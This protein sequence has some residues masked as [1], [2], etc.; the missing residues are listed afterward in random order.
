MDETAGSLNK[1]QKE[2]LDIA[3]KNLERLSRLI[4][5]I[6]ELQKINAGKIEFKFQENDLNEVAAEVQKSMMSLTEAKG[7]DFNINLVPD[8]PKADFDR[9]KI[10]QVFTNLVGNAIKFTG[11]GFITITT[12]YGENFIRAA[13]ADTGAGIPKE[14]FSR[15]FEHF[16]QLNDKDE[17][18]GLGLAISKEII[19]RHGGK[20]WV[21]SVEGRGSTFHFILPIKER[22][23]AR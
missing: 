1:D 6:L 16:E 5:E 3:K 8:M 11:K 10:V 4:N 9:D 22:R 15:I 2:F 20:I 17:G 13:V 19:E 18:S 14:D 7:L 21:E 23:I 12:S